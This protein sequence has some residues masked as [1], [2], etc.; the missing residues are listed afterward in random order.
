M[1]KVSSGMPMV[2]LRLWVLAMALLIAGCSKDDPLAQ[3][4]AQVQLLQENLE[5]KDSRA[6]LGQ[7]DARFRAQDEFDT[8]WARSTMLVLFHRYAHVKVIAV[9]RK[10]R[11]DPESPLTGY[12][13]AQVLVT[14]AQGLIPERAAPYVVRLEWRREG[15]D[16]KL[17]D[18]KWD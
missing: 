17:Y 10:T 12:T 18:L 7:M 16:W 2:G 1:G 15:S 13:E 14:G 11:I 6:V 9:G 8:D 3:L 4:E 5:A